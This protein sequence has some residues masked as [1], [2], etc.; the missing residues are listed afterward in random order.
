MKKLFQNN[1]TKSIRK[2]LNPKDV[3][4]LLS[5]E[6]QA[7]DERRHNSRQDRFREAVE[8]EIE[9][10]GISREEALLAIWTAAQKLS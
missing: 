3:M 2:S 1:R 6:L 5:R 4:S 9:A 10:C 8:K 7:L